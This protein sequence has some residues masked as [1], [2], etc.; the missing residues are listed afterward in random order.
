MK[1]LIEFTIKTKGLIP[2]WPYISVP[3]FG[4]MYVLQRDTYIV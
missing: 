4:Y 3:I 2:M 1:G